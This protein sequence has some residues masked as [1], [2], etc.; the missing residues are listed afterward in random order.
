LGR[1]RCV[2]GGTGVAER[3]VVIDKRL[4][5]SVICVTPQIGHAIAVAHWVGYVR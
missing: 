1:G 3:L 5:M 4:R 2:V